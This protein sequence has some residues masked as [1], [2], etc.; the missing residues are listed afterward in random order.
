MRRRPIHP[1]LLTVTGLLLVSLLGCLE[2]T[3]LVRRRIVPPP[4]LRVRIGRYEV[5]ST[6]VTVPSSSWR[7]GTPPVPTDYNVWFYIRPKDRSGTPYAVR[8][9]HLSLAPPY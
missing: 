6:P 1:V 8:L 9:V 4:A 7:S 3:Q 2:Y 5:D